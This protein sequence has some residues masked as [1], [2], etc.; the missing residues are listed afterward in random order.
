MSLYRTIPEYRCAAAATTVQPRRKAATRCAKSGSGAE[1][2]REPLQKKLN[3]THCAIEKHS[4]EFL[5][6]LQAARL[7]C[8]E[9]AG[10]F[11]WP[12]REKTSRARRIVGGAAAARHV[13]TGTSSNQLSAFGYEFS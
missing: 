7:F 3:S 8:A 5:Q 13:A 1:S 2:R 10:R 4:E 11:G 6:Q 9:F 12:E